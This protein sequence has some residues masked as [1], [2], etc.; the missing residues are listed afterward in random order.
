MGCLRII[1]PQ[2]IEVWGWIPEYAAR[3]Q[4][5]KGMY[6]ARMSNTHPGILPATGDTFGI[7]TQVKVLDLNLDETAQTFHVVA[8]GVDTGPII[9]ENRVRA[10]PVS[11]YPAKA[12]DTPEELFARVQRVEKAHLPLDLDTFLKDQARF[13]IK[14]NGDA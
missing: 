2:V 4:K 8:V 13:R 10:F 1:A 7:R 9:A 14:Q 11:K 3:D 5:H 6:F 12:A